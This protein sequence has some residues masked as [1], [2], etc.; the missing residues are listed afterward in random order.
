MVDILV[1]GIDWAQPGSLYYSHKH[2]TKIYTLSIHVKQFL[3][4]RA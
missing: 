3:T 2:R 1:P 4:Y